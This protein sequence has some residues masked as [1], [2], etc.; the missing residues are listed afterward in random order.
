MDLDTPIIFHH[1]GK[2]NHKDKIEDVRN[3]YWSATYNKDRSVELRCTQPGADIELVSKFFCKWMVILKNL[4]FVYDDPRVEL[5][6]IIFIR[7]T[8]LREMGENLSRNDQT[9]RR[10]K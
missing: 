8:F 7:P 6:M 5:L 2:R 1:K 4:K 3:E 9:I 10:N